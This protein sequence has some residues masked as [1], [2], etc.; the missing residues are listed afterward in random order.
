[1]LY[2]AQCLTD[3]NKHN[4]KL[5]DWR[6]RI[7]NERL[8]SSWVFHGVSPCD[9]REGLQLWNH[10]EAFYLTFLSWQSTMNLAE[11]RNQGESI[12]TM[13]DIRTYLGVVE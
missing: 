7:N 3:H 13:R 5:G 2:V 6:R 12:E 11:V 10:E 4:N 9:G 8:E 1:M